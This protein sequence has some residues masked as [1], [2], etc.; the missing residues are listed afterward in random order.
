MKPK[1]FIL[2]FSI[3]SLITTPATAIEHMP[4]EPQRSEIPL[5]YKLQTATDEEVLATSGN[6]YHEVE[7]KLKG[8]KEKS[9]AVRRVI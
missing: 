3:A 4:S 1:V 8:Y 9:Y 6:R 7:E 2:T 5:T